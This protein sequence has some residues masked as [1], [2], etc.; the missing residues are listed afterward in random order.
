[1]QRIQRKLLFAQHRKKVS[2]F[3]IRRRHKKHFFYDRLECDDARQKWQ[4]REKIAYSFCVCVC[5]CIIDCTALS[6]LPSMCISQ[7]TEFSCTLHQPHFPCNTEARADGK[8]SFSPRGG[9]RASKKKAERGRE[10]KMQYSGEK[11]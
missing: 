10:I 1:M 5:K 8:T 11:T 6:D 9:C 7:Q 4:R 2:R 3:P